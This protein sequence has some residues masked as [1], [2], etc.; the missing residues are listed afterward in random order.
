MKDKIQAANNFMKSDVVKYFDWALG[1]GFVT[2]GV[3]LIQNTG[4]NLTSVGTTAL[5]VIGLALAKIRPAVML[6]NYL[7]SKVIKKG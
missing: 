7:D 3:W 1:I 6:Q 2:Y 5:G 4:F